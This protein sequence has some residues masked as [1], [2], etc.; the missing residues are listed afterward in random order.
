MADICNG[1]QFC[2]ECTHKKLNYK[3]SL[4]AL[5]EAELIQL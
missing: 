4:G 2:F 1:L 3:L 5:F